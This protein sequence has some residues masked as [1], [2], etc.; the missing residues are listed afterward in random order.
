MKLMRTVMLALGAAS[1]LLASPA[2]AAPST[3][4]QGEAATSYSYG[5]GDGGDAWDAGPVFYGGQDTAFFPASGCSASYSN[6][7]ALTIQ[8]ATVMTSGVGGTICGR[9]TVSG[10]TTAT[11][12]F[13]APNDTWVTVSLPNQ[14]VTTGGSFTVTWHTNG[15]TPGYANLFVDSYSGIGV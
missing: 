5:C 2:N 6:T 8:S 4:V 14:V 11:A 9:V 10:L 15:G 13:C 1:V 7:T 3:T 12:S